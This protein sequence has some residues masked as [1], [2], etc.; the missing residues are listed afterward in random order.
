MTEL[1]KRAYGMLDRLDIFLSIKS[2]KRYNTIDILLQTTRICQ[3]LTHFVFQ[4]VCIFYYDHEI[5]SI[6]C[7]NL[8]FNL[9]FAILVNKSTRTTSSEPCNG[10][11]QETVRNQLCGDLHNYFD[12]N[13]SY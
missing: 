11:I 9:V 1:L 12:V 10:N 4:F 8:N 13:P 7:Q 3:Y 2:L 6:D 5:R